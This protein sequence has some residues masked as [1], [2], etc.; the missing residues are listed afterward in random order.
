MRAKDIV[1]ERRLAHAQPAGIVP[2]HFVD[3]G[4]DLAARGGVRG[5]MSRRPAAQ[6]M[7]RLVRPFEIG[8]FKELLE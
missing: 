8:I 7:M 5:R 2:F 3:Q 6:Q 4:A 1:V